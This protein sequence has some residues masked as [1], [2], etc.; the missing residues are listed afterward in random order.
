VVVG[1]AIGAGIHGM[2]PRFPAGMMAATRVGQCRRRVTVCHVSNSAGNH[3][4]R[5]GA[6]EGGALGTVLAF[7]MSV[8]RC[9]AQRSSFCARY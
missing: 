6:G 5:R 9:A 8:I 2:C 7:M 3:P 4:H 1:I